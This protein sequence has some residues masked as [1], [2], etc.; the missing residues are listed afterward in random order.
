[1]SVQD[2][3]ARFE[4][5]TLRCDVREHRSQTVTR[6]IW[7]LRSRIRHVIITSSYGLDT[8][9]ETFDVALKIDLTFKRLVN[10]GPDVL[11]VRDMDI[12]IISASQ[13]V[14]M[15]ELCW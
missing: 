8:V 2:Y 5:L 10:A 15:L 3:I 1:M 4:D 7:G 9:E 6:F 14:D 12:M 11:S 13:K